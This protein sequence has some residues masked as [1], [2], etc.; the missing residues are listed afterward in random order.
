M[1][2]YCIKDALAH[3]LNIYKYLLI[4]VFLFAKSLMIKVD[5]IDCIFFKSCDKVVDENTVPSIE[6]IQSVPSC[7]YGNIQSVPCNHL[8]YHTDYDV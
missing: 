7:H 6:N 5:N 1:R 8:P 4:Y 2:Y 3:Y